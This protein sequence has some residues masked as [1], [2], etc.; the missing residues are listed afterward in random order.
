MPYQEA[1][2][3]SSIILA[4]NYILNRTMT[5]DEFHE[6]LLK[7]VNFEKENFGYYEDTSVSKTNEIIN[8]FYNYKNTEIVSNANINTIKKILNNEGIV[9]VP[10]AG[11]NI[12]NPYYN[13]PGPY[14]HMLVIKGYDEQNFITHDVGTKKGENFKYRYDV[15]IDNIH[16][17]NPQFIERGENRIIAVYK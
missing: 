7:I 4:M 6:E 5:L 9:I 10:L 13:P 3:E 8:T 12:G 11:R 15:L 2:E 17:F 16:D 1:C 14:Y